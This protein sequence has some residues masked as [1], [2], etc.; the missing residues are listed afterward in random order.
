MPLLQE[1]ARRIDLIGYED[2]DALFAVQNTNLAALDSYTDTDVFGK[3][4]IMP[5]DVQ[6]VLQC[7]G[8]VD[9]V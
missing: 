9:Q 5:I 1:R 7:I 2:I 6:T 3:L 8:L 4:A